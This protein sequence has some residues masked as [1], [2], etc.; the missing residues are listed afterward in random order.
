M[1]RQGL[2]ELGQGSAERYFGCGPGIADVNPKQVTILV[3]SAEPE[4]QPKA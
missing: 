1:V 3:D 4:S 2:P